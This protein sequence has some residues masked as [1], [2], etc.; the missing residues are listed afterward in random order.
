[1]R[2]DPYTDPPELEP[3]MPQI[4]HQSAREG[5]TGVNYT[6]GLRPEFRACDAIDAPRLI[7]LGGVVVHQADGVADCLIEREADE[8]NPY[9]FQEYD[10]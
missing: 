6:F 3:I 7:P 1:M 2:W 4:E 10:E 9:A 5:M 8:R